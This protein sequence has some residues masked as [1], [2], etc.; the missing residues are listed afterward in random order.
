MYVNGLLSADAAVAV[1]TTNTAK[2]AQ[3][4]HDPI[5]AFSVTPA[6]APPNRVIYTSRVSDHLRFAWRFYVKTYSNLYVS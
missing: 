2:F 1:N 3:K 4:Q 5:T 6:S